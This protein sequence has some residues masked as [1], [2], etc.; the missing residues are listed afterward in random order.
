M[1]EH[2]IIFNTEM[3]RAI[4]EGRKTQTRRPVRFKPYADEKFGVYPH[5]CPFGQIGDRIWVRETWRLDEFN[6]FEVIYKAD[7]PNHPTELVKWR[8]SIHMPKWAA[9]IWLEIT[10]IRV[11]RIQD[12]TP[13]E[14]EREGLNLVGY[15]ET[16]E[17][18]IKLWNSCNSN[19]NLWNHNP[20]VW[21]IEFVRWMG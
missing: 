20:W 7:Y 21:V 19:F 13:I 12:I 1:K 16:K 11:E 15:K 18:F 4:Q 8:P 17:N 5:E 6:P 9:R 14:W 2:P 3:V 10:D